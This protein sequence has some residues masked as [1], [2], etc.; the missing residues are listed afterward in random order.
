[1]AAPRWRYVFADL[2]TDR[3]ID[4]LEVAGAKFDDRINQAGA[5]SGSIPVPNST[6]AARARQI[7]EV[8]TVVYAYRGSEIWAGPYILWNVTPSQD[9]RGGINVSLQGA[10]LESYFARREIREDLAFVGEDQLDIARALVLSVQE[11][12][13]GNLGITVD[14]TTSGVLRDRF[15]YEAEGAFYGQRLAELAAVE[16]GFEYRIVAYTDPGTGQRVRAFI[17]GYPQLGGSLVDHVVAQPGNVISWSRLGDGTRGATSFRATGDSINDD[18]TA[19]SIPLTSDV[20]ERSDLL[21]AGWPLLDRTDAYQ[22]VRELTTLNQYAAAKAAALG[23]T[24]RIL[25]VAVRLP[26][27]T[28]ALS[29]ASLGDRARILLKN[30]YHGQLTET[31]RVI[32]MEITPNGRGAG[33][34]TAN[35]IFQTDETAA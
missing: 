23:G 1:M 3:T 22:G 2:L 34:D 31:W 28:D 10:G 18:I 33:Q 21:A 24:A 8:R 32:G 27:D 35:L 13:E 17:T 7:E 12:D 11:R 4:E 16:D 29:P 20:V 25:S 5:F 15:Y 6:V 19:Q 9:G 14:D 30:D 26:A